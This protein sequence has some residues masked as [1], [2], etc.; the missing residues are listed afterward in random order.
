GIRDLHV[1]GVQTCALPISTLHALPE[2]IRADF[3]DEADLI[4]AI[5]DY[6]AGRVFSGTP[7]ERTTILCCTDSRRD[8]CC[9]RYGFSTYKALE[10]GR[11]SCRG[12]RRLTVRAV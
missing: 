7:D 12:G 6:I 3:T 8:A 5:H 4:T 11:A 10:I 1:T 2:N 9:A